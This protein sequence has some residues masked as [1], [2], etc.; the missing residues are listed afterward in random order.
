M[1]KR[2]GA[3]TDPCG[4]PFLRRRNLLLWPFTM[5]SEKLRLPTIS[6]IMLT[7]S[8]SIRYQSQQL[9]SEAEM[10]YSVASSCEVDK[11]SSGLLL[12][13]KA[14]LDVLCQQGDL[15]YGR[16]PVSK[17]R[18]LLRGQWVDDW[19]DTSVD[20]PLE[21]FK[22]E[23][24]QRYAT[25]ALW[26]PQWLFW[27]RDRIVS[28]LLQILEFCIGACKMWGSHKTKIWEPTQCGV[29]TPGRRNPIPETFLASGAWGQQKAPLA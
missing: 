18:L 12:N 28:A 17:A 13:R 1:L 29:W 16:P 22:E 8:L 23:T 11:H 24:Q 25:V 2:R 27:L 9:V 7:I 6:M 10:P 26:V 5:A 3:R 4:T 19:F 14:I 21:D 15:I 20:E